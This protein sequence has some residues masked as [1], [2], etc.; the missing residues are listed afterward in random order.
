MLNSIGVSALQLAV[1]ARVK[2]KV[3]VS[4]RGRIDL[5]RRQCSV[6]AISFVGI[7]VDASV[8]VQSQNSSVQCDR[9]C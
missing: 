3:K 7:A 5:Y 8:T 9:Q 6:T 1:R 2:V 4:A